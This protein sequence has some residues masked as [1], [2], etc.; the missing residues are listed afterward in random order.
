MSDGENIETGALSMPVPRLMYARVILPSSAEKR[1]LSGLASSRDVSYSPVPSYQRAMTPP[2]S[3]PKGLANFRYARVGRRG[4]KSARAVPQGVFAQR[5][6]Q[7][8]EQP[9]AERVVADEGVFA[10]FGRD[11]F[12]LLYVS[13]EL[14]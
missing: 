8:D 6:Q 7:M 4:V 14:A 11:L 3:A 1:A 2:A 13:G 9:P 10:L 5:S 12:Q